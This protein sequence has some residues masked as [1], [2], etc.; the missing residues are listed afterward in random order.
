MP[1]THCACP[2][3]PL[4]VTRGD[5]GPPPTAPPPP[6]PPPR[7][8]TCC[9]ACPAPPWGPCVH[10]RTLRAGTAPFM[11][12]LTSVTAASP[13]PLLSMLAPQ[14]MV[15][16]VASAAGCA[17]GAWVGAGPDL[18]DERRRLQGPKGT[19]WWGREGARRSGMQLPMPV[20]VLAHIH[21]ASPLSVSGQRSSAL[22]WPSYHNPRARTTVA[23]TS[24]GAGGLPPWWCDGQ[25][26]GAGRCPHH[27]GA[28]PRPPHLSDR[29]RRRRAGQQ[30]QR[31]G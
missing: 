31:L 15:A 7:R 22:A 1:L 14:P 17:G 8:P 11:A 13:R 27:D 18:A 30:L 24:G 16:V 10:T 19:R 12:G 29:A 21:P 6:P 3:E 28:P 26:V 25:G 5:F 23:H 9:E 2:G 4:A 20:H